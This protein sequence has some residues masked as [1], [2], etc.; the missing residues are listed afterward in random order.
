MIRSRGPLLSEFRAYA[1]LAAFPI[2]GVFVFDWWNV[3]W[4]SEHG[5]H[6]LPLEI[7]SHREEAGRPLHLIKYALLLLALRGLAGGRL[8]HMVPITTRSRPWLVIVI[9]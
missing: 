7:A 1:A 9:S 4:A 6:V 5:S 8:W 3:G 2:I